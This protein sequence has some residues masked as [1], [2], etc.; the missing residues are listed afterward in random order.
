VTVRVRTK[1]TV[2]A[3]VLFEVAFASTSAHARKAAKAPVAPPTL[4]A[5]QQAV[6]TEIVNDTF[7]R[8]RR[9]P[10]TL[11]LCLDV[12]LAQAFDEDA[13]PPPPPP[14]RGR[15]KP[16]PLPETPPLPIIRGAPPELVA[17]LARPWRVV[18]SALS[19]RLDPRE[20]FTLNDAAHR[21]A[22]L[23]TLHLAPDVA[24]GTVRIDWTDGHDPTAGSSRDCTATRVPRGWSVHCSGT[25]FQ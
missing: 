8:P 4:N 19:C 13:A 16:A 5:D 10:L 21:P 20:T 11:A 17:A 24:S 14:R 22:Q 3:L 25:W 23:V 12:Q 2:A 9:E 1:P 18:A 6:V 15:H 7:R